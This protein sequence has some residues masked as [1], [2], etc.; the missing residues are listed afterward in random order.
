MFPLGTANLLA[1]YLQLRPEPEPFAAML[2]EG[3]AVR[4]DA[5][6]VTW[7]EPATPSC[8]AGRG[9][10]PAGNTPP[11]RVPFAN[12]SFSSWPESDSMRSW[13]NAYT[14]S[15]AAMVVIFGCGLMPNQFLSPSVVTPILE[16]LSVRAAT[17]P[18]QNGDGIAHDFVP[19]IGADPA[20]VAARWIFVS[21][22]LRYAG[23][24]NFS[25]AAV[26]TDGLLDV[27]TF[28]GG[29]LARGLWYVSQV[30]LGRHGS[31]ADCRQFRT[32]RLRIWADANGLIQLDG[33]PAGCLPV[34]I[35]VLPRRIR[36]IVPARLAASC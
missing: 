30:W 21:N 36:L 3:H 11:W 20:T 4:L 24:L 18:G 10:A 29:S 12:A 6:Q 17:V 8:G 19:G 16:L 5:G 31:L 27:C 33:D 23:G 32:S 35:E 26:A 7:A 25:P 15:E 14:A 9:G 2:V 28:D 34:E 1:G 22:L 13:S